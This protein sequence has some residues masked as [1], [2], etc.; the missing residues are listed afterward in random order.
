MLKIVIKS[1]FFLAIATVM[2]LL[3][4]LFTML[5]WNAVMPDLFNFPVVSL[6]QA[7]ILN[8]LTTCLVYR[9]K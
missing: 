2:Y 5:S 4:S 8:L 7:A 6:N 3:L 9:G 1:I